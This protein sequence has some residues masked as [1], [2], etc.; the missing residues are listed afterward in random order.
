MAK[1]RK[2]D[3]KYCDLS[4]T[5]KDKQFTTPGIHVED[6][7]YFAWQSGEVESISYSELNNYGIT[8]TEVTD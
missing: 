4:F 8:Y 3:I 2:V 1:K 5:I 7:V 6:K